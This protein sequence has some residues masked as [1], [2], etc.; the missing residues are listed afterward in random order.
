MNKFLAKS[1]GQTLI[2]HSNLVNKI[3]KEIA[4]S[5]MCDDDK[6][7]LLAIGI[8]SLLHDVGKCTSFF[9]KQRLKSNFDDDNDIEDKLPKKYKY[10][11][12]EIG[13]AF[14]SRYL[15]LENNLFNSVLDVVYWHHGISNEINKNYDTDIVNDLTS[16]DIS[17][18]KEFTEYVLSN[19]G[20][21][22]FLEEK[23]YEPKK[24]PLY[25]V[26][27]ENHKI[28]NSKN[29]FVRT[30]VI[31]ADRLA[32]EYFNIE[33]NKIPSLIKDFNNVKYDVDITKH[34]FYKNNRFAQQLKIASKIKK[35]TQINAP[36]GFGKTLLTM[37]WC[38]FRGKSVIW[39]C[40]R[41]IVAESV[42]NSVIE[43]L[44]YF[45]C[46]SIKVELFLT[47][48]VVKSNHQSSGFDSD[49]IITNIDNYLAPTVNNSHASKLHRIL[50]SD[51]VFD[52]F[53]ELI[54]KDN[55]LFAC[56]INLMR[57]RT[58][59]TNAHT[60]LLSATPT[61]MSVLWESV[62]N[63]TLILPN[64]HEHYKAVHQKKYKLFLTEDDFIDLKTNNNLYVVNSI[65]TAQI[66]K[67]RF[68]CGLMLHSEFEKFDKDKNLEQ[69]YKLYDKS[70]NRDEIKTNVIGTHVIQASLDVSF[71]NLFES[72][73]SPQSFLQRNGR[74]NRF[75]DCKTKSIIN[76]CMLKTRS[77]DSV[78]EILYS[79]NLSNLWF[80]FLKEYNEKDLSLDE[81]Y[82]IY[83]SFERQ[84][85]KILIEDL[86]K[87]VTESL[88][89]LTKIYPVKPFNKSSKKTIKAGGNKL[90]STGN[91]IFVIA[92]YYN[93]PNKFT[94]PFS[95]TIRKNYS[96]EFKED[97][98]TENKIKDIWTLLRNT[99]DD[100]YD[101]NELIN[102]KKYITLDGIRLKAK[103]Y[104]TP[105]IRF[106]KVYHPEYGL[107]SKETL[108]NIIK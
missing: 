86:I 17:A 108:D 13:W 88:N 18:M 65:K 103:N 45:N 43:Q 4:I 28:I 72:V 39:V 82:T 14:L 89:V 31:S 37:L 1:N 36:A 78:R 99:N 52:E 21:S 7:L 2:E 46:F 84:H 105:Y 75:G 23:E 10:R 35:T 50:N 41:N 90:R 11:H 32:S 66:L 95:V 64:K 100:R 33:E 51:V 61:N 27:G 69:L 73:L 60:L 97:S 93:D 20:V 48:E 91:D 98:R 59:W 80:D 25:Y 30:C 94:E 96:E 53:H 63:K 77:E 68:D 47:G 83:N 79:K 5:S 49:F 92:Q 74:N 58:Q 87:K 38:F 26:N 3:A 101:F 12:N 42:Y 56:F 55:A 71:N 62:N 81:L 16:E 54:S 57:T 29:L 85:E 40:P 44:N 76:I 106:D 19:L 34:K 102:S 107:I 15:K 70:S 9:Q 22:Y 67:K 104:N 24:S 8:G 6:E